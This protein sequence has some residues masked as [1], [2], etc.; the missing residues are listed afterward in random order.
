MSKYI[1]KRLL[2]MIPV[3]ARGGISGVCHPVADAG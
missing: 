2:Y 3:S 1:I